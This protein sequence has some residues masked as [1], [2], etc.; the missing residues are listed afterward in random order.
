MAVVYPAEVLPLCLPV[1]LLGSLTVLSRSYGVWRHGLVAH[2]P[3]MFPFRR[4]DRADNLT[5]RC[6]C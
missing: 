3:H 4:A 5:D 6:A 1:L 2:S